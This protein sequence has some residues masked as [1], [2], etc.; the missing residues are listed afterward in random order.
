M[1]SYVQDFSSIKIKD[2]F[3]RAQ[4]ICDTGILDII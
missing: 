4:H 1:D 2:A 3:C